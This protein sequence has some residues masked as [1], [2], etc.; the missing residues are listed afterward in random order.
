MKNACQLY[1]SENKNSSFQFINCL[2]L[3]QNVLKWNGNYQ[4][5]AIKR[6]KVSKSWQYTSSSN[7]DFSDNEIREVRPIGQKATK[8]R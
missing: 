8:K 6:I 4:E 5:E 2:R 3:L 7:A 1:K